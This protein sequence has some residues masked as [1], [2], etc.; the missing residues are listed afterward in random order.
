VGAGVPRETVSVM[1]LMRKS[2]PSV[3]TNEGNRSHTVTAPFTKPM[4]AAATSP[5]STAIHMGA[6]ASFA[7]TIMNGANANTMPAERSMSPPII[8]MISPNAMIATGAMNCDKA[9]VAEQEIVVCEFEVSGQQHGH[10]QDT[11]LGRPV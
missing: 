6:P 10:E 5:A 1:P 7:N 2:V 11:Q 3:V 4:I 8:N 9:R